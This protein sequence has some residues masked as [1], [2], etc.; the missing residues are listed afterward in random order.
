MEIR[1]FSRKK[2]ITE[3]TGYAYTFSIQEKKPK[4]LGKT[5]PDSEKDSGPLYVFGRRWGSNKWNVIFKARYHEL[6]QQWP[7]LPANMFMHLL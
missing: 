3:V 7:L 5:N 2:I 4:I 6:A 1:F